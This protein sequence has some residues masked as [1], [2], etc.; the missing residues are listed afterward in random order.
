M[1]RIDSAAVGLLLFG[2][3]LVLFASPL[4]TWWFSHNPP[5]YSAFCIG[6]G[7]IALIALLV[8]RR[9]HEL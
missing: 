4:T 6:F 2:V 1:A 7:Y 5:W 9:G 8:G 3:G